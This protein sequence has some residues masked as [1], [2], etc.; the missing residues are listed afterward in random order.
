MSEPEKKEETVQIVTAEDKAGKK[1]IIKKATVKR[2][3]SSTPTIVEPKNLKRLRNESEIDKFD[4]FS[5]S[6]SFE[7]YLKYGQDSRKRP[8]ANHLQSMKSY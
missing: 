8:T 2:E 3:T 6:F 4:I 5:D 1:P 7:H